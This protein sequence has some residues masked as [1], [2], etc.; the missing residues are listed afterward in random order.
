MNILD[1]LFSGNGGKKKQ[2]E[3]AEALV[4]KKNK[5]EADMAKIEIQSI[6][7]KKQSEV[8]LQES[9]RLADMVDSV[10]RNIAIATGGIERGK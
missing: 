9:T 6:K 5:F 8:T 3:I 4:V 2:Q 10:T 7:L 1:K